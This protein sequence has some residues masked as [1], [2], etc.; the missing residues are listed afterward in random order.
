MTNVAIEY[1]HSEFSHKKNG[2]FHS[3]VSLQEGN[4]G[5]VHCFS[6]VV[7]VFCCA[8]PTASGKTRQQRET[9]D[10]TLCSTKLRG[11]TQRAKEPNET[12]DKDWFQWELRLQFI[13]GRTEELIGCMFPDMIVHW[14]CGS[15]SFKLLPKIPR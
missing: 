9:A 4:N 7:S 14:I 15:R 12:C 10:V 3:S 2:V 6:I 11:E 8:Y 1:S 13:A 5:D